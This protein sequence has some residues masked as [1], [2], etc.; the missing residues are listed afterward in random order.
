MTIVYRLGLDSQ[1][2]S[3][4]IYPIHRKDIGLNVKY[5]FP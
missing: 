1:S 3:N 4:F 2:I 5:I